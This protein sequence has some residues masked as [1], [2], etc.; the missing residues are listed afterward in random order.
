MWEPMAI[1]GI[2]CR[3]PGGASSPASFWRLLAEGVD[4]IQETPADR[5]DLSQVFDADRSRPGRMYTRWGGFVEG[6]DRFDPG[7]FGFSPREAQRIDPQHR[8][9]LEV[10]WESLEDAGQPADGLAGSR[11]GVFVGISTHDYG[12]LQAY[13]QNR[14]LIDSHTNS[15]GAGSIAAN[16]ISYVYDFRGPSFV[17]DT[18]C[19]SSLVA[20]HLA[21][22]SLRAGECELALAG[23]V[24]AVLNPEL[25]IGFC[26]AS[27]ISPDGR[28]KAFAAEANGYVRGEGAGLIVLKP[29]SRA[30]ADGDRIYA[31]VRGSAINEDGRTNGM[32]VPGLPA[33]QQV[34]RDAYR[35][36]GV[37]PGDVHY[38]EA[39]GPGTPVGDPIEAE[40]LATVLACDRPAG[41]VLRIGSVKTNIGHL[42]AGSGI[43]GLVKAALVLKHRHIPPSLHFRNP[44]PAIPFDRYRLRV[45]AEGEPWPEAAPAFAGINSFGF[46]GA[47]AHVVL[48]GPPPEAVPKEEAVPP[49]ADLLAVSA[50][51]AESLR[52]LARSYRDLCRGADPPALSDLAAA[53]ALRRSH[54]EHRLGIVGRDLETL[55]DNLDAFLNDETRADVVVGRASHKEPPRVAFVFAGMG[56]Q[57]WGM[58]RQLLARE[59]VFRA[60]IDECDRLI[61]RHAEWSLVEELL[62]DEPASRVAEADFAQPVNFAF[63]AALLALWRHWGVEPAAVVGHSAGEIAAVYATGAMDLG[64]AVRVAFH[65]GRLQ[66]RATGHGRMMAVGLGLDALRPLLGEYEGRL[67]VA[68]VN[69]P[70]S[71]TISGDTDAVE[72]ASARIQKRGAFCR[73]MS[74]QV[75]YHSHHMDAIEGELLQSLANLRLRAGAIPIVSE[76]TGDRAEG[77]GFDAAYWWRNI[78]QPVLFGDAVLRLIAEG[79]DTFLEISPHPVLGASVGECLRHAERPGVVLASLRRN[80]DDRAMLLRGLAGL[81]ARGVEPDWEK[82]LGRPRR[83]VALPLYAW[84]KERVWLETAGAGA[85]FAAS[86]GHDSNILGSRVPTVTPHWE[87]DLKSPALQYLNDHRIHGAIVFP[88]AA[89]VA[90][91][92]EA[93]A[94]VSGGARLGLEGVEFRKALFIPED[95]APRVQAVYEPGTRALQIHAQNGSDAWT[96]HAGCRVSSSSDEAPG[97]L[98]LAAVRERCRR[99]MAHQEFYDEVGK[100]GFTFGPRF[101][102]VERLFQGDGEALGLVR[103]PEDHAVTVN[104]DRVHPALFDAGLQVLIGAVTSRDQARDG[105]LP[106]FLPTRAARVVSHRPVGSTFWSHATVEEL[107]PESFQGTVSL[108]DEDGNVL[109]RVE[110]LRAK[111]LEDTAGAG[112]SDASDLLYRSVWEEKPLAPSGDS[113]CLPASIAATVAPEADRLSRELGFAGY[114]RD[115]EPGLERIARAFFVR[116]LAALGLGLESGATVRTDALPDGTPLPE[117]RRRQLHA[118]AGALVDVGVLEP[119]GD[120]LRVTLV[121]PAEDPLALI[122]AIR[123]ERPGWSSVL[124]LLSRC[125]LSLADVLAGRRDGPD[126]LFS[127]DGLQAMTAF[128]GGAPSCRLFN[129]LTAESVAA[130][131]AAFPAGRELRVLEVGAGTGGT[132]RYVLPRLPPE[133]TRFTFTDVSP[134][135]VSLARQ[136]LG[137]GVA[138]QAFDVARDPREQGLDAGGFDL[139][140]G[141]NVVHGT[142]DVARTL[143]HLR[144]LLA[145]GGLLVLQEI[146]RRLRWLDVVFGVTDGWWA[147]ADTPLRSDHALLDPPTWRRILGEA[148]FE[149]AV[150]LSETEDAVPGQ[151]ILMARAPQPAHRTSE[152]WLVLAD[153]KGVGERLAQRLRG[154]GDACVVARAGDAFRQVAPCTFEVP[155]G[156]PDAMRRLLG[157]SSAPTGVVHLWS[158]DMPVEPP[159]SGD[160]LLDAQAHGYASMLD[161]LHAL[162]AAGPPKVTRCALVTAGAQAIDD[163]AERTAVAQAP[164]WGFARG[165]LHE[166]P[167]LR[168]LLVD[169]GP[170][171]VPDDAEGLAREVTAEAREDEV[172]LRDGRRYVRRMTRLALGERSAPDAPPE[173]ARGRA[174]RAEVGAAGALDTLR[175]REMPRR[176]LGRD[177]IEIEVKAASLNFRDVMFAMGMLPAAAFDNMLSAGAL[178]VD[179][180]GVVSAVG[181]DVSHVRP[182]DEVVALSP[183]SLA[184]HAVTRDLVVRKP[185]GLSFAE[186][187]ALPLAYVTALYSLENMARL[188][189]GERVLIHAATGGVGLAALSV[190]QRAGAEIF[191]TAGSDPKREYLRERGVR[192]VFDSRSLDFADQ[193]LRI[194]R[195]R[196]VDVVLNSLAGE[197]IAKGLSVLAPRGR[198]LE[199]GKADIYRNA[200]LALEHFSRNLSFC[201]IQIDLLCNTDRAVLRE[202]MLEMVEG[203]ESGA[204][205]PLPTQA[206]PV[207]SLEEGLRTLAQARHL[208]KVVV[209]MDDPDV[210][211]V[212]ET[213]AGNVI[214]PDATYL[215]TGGLGGVGAALARFLSARGARHLALASRGAAAAESSEL[216]TD[217]RAKGVEVLLL[218]ADVSRP[219]DVERALRAADRPQAPLKGV[220]HGAMVIDDAPLSE[221]DRGRFERVMAPKAA[222]AW[223]L[224]LATR[225]R[226]LDH[227]VLFSS[228]TSVYGNARQ[229]NYGAAN[230]FLDALAGHRRAQGLPGLTVN[231]GV[232]EDVGYVAERRDVGE[233]LARQGQHGFRAEQGFAAM[234]SLIERGQ[235]QATVSRTDWPA[236]AEANPVMGSSPRFRALVEARRS[237][238]SD[239]AKAGARALDAV[240]ALGAA[241]R[242]AEVAR[243]LRRRMAKILGA[244]PERVETSVPLTDL[245]MDSLMAVE[246]MTALK[247][248]FAID[249]PAVKLLQGVTL[250][251]LQAKVVEHLQAMGGADVIETVPVPAAVAPPAAPVLA[252]PVTVATPRPEPPPAAP[253]A[254]PAPV[255][256]WTPLQRVARGVVSAVVRAVADTHVAG[257]QNMPTSGPV[258]IA[259]NHLSMW[260][261]PVLLR[262]AE[263]RTVIFAAE[264]LRRFPWMHW[265]LHELWD[266]I[267]LRRGEGDTDAMEQALGVLRA[268]GV[269]GLSPEG[270]RNPGG[271]SRGLTGVAHLAFRSGAP[272]V[273]MALFGQER[274]PSRA[275]RLR[276]TRVDVRIAPAVRAAGEP[277]AQAI[278]ALTDR[279]MV[280]IARLLPKEYRGVYASAVEAEQ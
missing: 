61:R 8:M 29:L 160:A 167:E 88:G 59:P 17:V 275:P 144:T 270:I 174:F 259:A 267:Y 30:L 87:V 239:P 155:I 262:F 151:S 199:I 252:V 211:I 42:E 44:S 278:Q 209:T 28:C 235:V 273:P 130:A 203:I 280:E 149:E 200:D 201:A 238:R 184:S 109:L 179:C 62:K 276:R 22:Q 215:I 158:L 57:W 56:P 47:N 182:G 50:R 6:I 207:R 32:T 165:L 24:Q 21:C 69:S 193:I 229:G 183:A 40:A 131:V 48:E 15:G 92:L 272:I 154:R 64:E 176:R 70:T 4:A 231:W 139:V 226:A 49:R 121:P 16:R 72:E 116:A 143:G 212:P 181:E 133:R 73:V 101:M 224:H 137:E 134:L 221:L 178:G 27:M 156:Q 135:F 213:R 98:D 202:T 103:L 127:G 172:A 126:V 253:A 31:L 39:H 194:T 102:G 79:Y 120:V 82:A 266:A 277:T 108:H 254:E 67:C 2:G 228:I 36:A 185:A 232:F 223:N 192:H 274:I 76:V 256:R 218:S 205:A 113:W 177:E 19:S 247:N 5:F 161:L 244:A 164:L 124:D 107:T 54:S 210:P 114:Y 111:T 249:V 264:E 191:A 37:R 240:L 214:R 99:E 43:A 173:P 38:V 41:E 68:A 89:Y 175:L 162:P 93:A 147:F 159:A 60:V 250:D 263:R 74:V 222:G 237:A 20:V 188:R 170:E 157:E 243:L 104:G 77:V 190:A 168:P 96:L 12:D 148:G 233:Y 1:I 125:G 33:Q 206:F 94:E 208:G 9:L 97:A 55:A 217:L 34:L 95:A 112:G 225:D 51:S 219:Q 123:A 265:T 18:A 141:A 271:L 25:T 198:F 251:Q 11:T 35:H 261:A 279:V 71:L 3:F 255:D 46:G 268:G 241:E 81:Y 140:I 78:R 65:R 23:G 45:T 115:V 84:N 257:A 85:S 105:K 153:R 13:P 169:L 122:E 197:A 246:L 248:D 14:A 245:G 100:R 171:P 142:P 136:E 10:A 234:E 216:V 152:S 258:L 242:P 80:D 189:P 132:T 75:P 58:G 106:A 150:T 129:A 119:R 236:W 53:A 180:S 86:N 63:Q 90:M 260:D 83:R 220:F 26:K 66:H 187:A 128:Y 186:A 269:I 230:A 117:A 163:A 118:L 91:A 7:F 146:T 196:G 204:L 166:H 145:P 110:G 138:C 227:F 52:G 195:G